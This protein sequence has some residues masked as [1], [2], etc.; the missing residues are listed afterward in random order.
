MK[1]DR[2]IIS[3]FGLSK[4]VK[5]SGSFK[6][7]NRYG[8][9]DWLAPEHATVIKDHEERS[10]I[11]IACDTFSMG[12]VFFYFLTKG[13]MPFESED[14]KNEG[15]YNFEKLPKEHKKSFLQI[16]EK[17]IRFNRDERPEMS[18]VVDELTKMKA[19]IIYQGEH[20]Q[21][22][23][24]IIGRGAFATVFKG[25]FKGETAAVKQILIEFNEP[26]DGEQFLQSFKHPNI[27][28]LF[29]IEQD[30]L[31]RYHAYRFCPFDLTNWGHEQCHEPIASPMDG[32]RHMADGLDYI[33]RKG[34]VH[35]DIN[36]R[37][38]LI[39]EEGGRL[40]IS[41]FNLMKKLDEEGGYTGH[42]WYGYEKWLAPERNQYRRKIK[43]L[44]D[45]RYLNRVT[46]AC[47]TYSMA[48]VFLLL[49]H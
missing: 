29:H 49:P 22:T 20:I 42:D 3:D 4:E 1:G 11:T 44:P 9:R 13:S 48:C 38:I 6:Q 15:T 2:L 33:H 8:Q 24:N 21:C 18:H 30:K 37:N 46:T 43:E 34:Y 35:R 36:P 31:F 16:I 23:K 45:S 7:T 39:S 19:G 28:D 17:M 26:L 41:G 47:D 32:L 27:I 10:K 14:K 25:S 12:C 40:V 5:E